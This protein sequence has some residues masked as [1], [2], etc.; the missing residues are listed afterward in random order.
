M[1]ICVVADP[2]WSQNSSIVRSRGEVYSQ[3]LENLIQSVNWAENLAAFQQCGA[4]FYIGDFFDSCQLNSEEISAMREVR[5]SPISHVFLTGNHETNVGSLEY[6]TTDIFNLCPNS[7][8]I[9]KPEIYTID[10]VSGCEIAF[11][12]YILER[13]RKSLDEYFPVNPALK[14]IIFSHNDLKDVRYGPII[15]REGFTVDEIHNN[16]SLFL[17]GHIHHGFAVTDKI[18]NVG[19]LTGQNFTEDASKFDHCVAIVNTDNLHIDYY[20]NPHAFNFYKLDFTHNHSVTDLK[21]MI[22]NLKSNAVITLKVESSFIKE[23]RE[24]M[25]SVGKH[26]VHTYRIITNNDIVQALETN[27]VDLA[28]MDHI[29]QFRNYVMENIGTTDLIMGELNHVIGGI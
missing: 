14:R 22:S 7:V 9:N 24:F 10:G 5:W 15:S 12:P 8:V 6:S 1:R 17:N 27:D 26:F 2:H 11:L 25:E 3:R 13:D 4:I 28:K 23:A 18:I 19:N 16:C 29:E 21:S 20:C